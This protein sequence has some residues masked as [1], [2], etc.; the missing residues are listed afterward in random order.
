MRIVRSQKSEVRSFSF[1]VCCLLFTVYFLLVSCGKKGDPT[2]KS[3]EKPDPP[4]GLRAIHRESEIILFWDFPKNKE[5]MIKGFYLMK[6]IPPHPPLIPPLVRGDAEGSKGGRGDFERVSFIENDKRSYIDRDFKIG[7]KY[8]YKIISQNLRGITSIDSNIIEIEPKDPPAPPRRPLFKIEYDSLTLTWED[9][10]DGILYNIYK[11]DK[12]GLY[13]LTPVNEEPIKGTSFRDSFSIKRP[14]YYIIRNLRGG[15][16]R[17]EGSASEELEINP[18]EFVPFPPEGLQAVITEEKVYLIW[19]EA[20]ETWVV[21]YRVYREIDKKEGFI[22]IGET[23]TPAFLDKEKPLTK[24][25]Y[26]VT[27]LGPSQEGLASEIRDVVFVP[28]R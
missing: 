4:T 15:E 28:Y 17:D 25:N 23:Q 3:Y 16:A 8:R 12:K 11:S 9:A 27:A 18:S 1:T 7:S 5:Q 22:F 19:R 20:P 21:G 2:L 24:R 6:S 26:R 14:V 13:P 10:G